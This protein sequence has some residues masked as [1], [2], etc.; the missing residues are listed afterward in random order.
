MPEPIRP[1]ALN[2]DHEAA[3]AKVDAL[4]DRALEG[5]RSD[6][7]GALVLCEEAYTLAERSDYPRGL[8]QSLNIRSRCQLRLANPEAALK[9]AAAALAQF[10]TLGDDEGREAVLSTFGIIE[11]D[12][13]HYITS[14]A[15]SQGEL[16]DTQLKRVSYRMERMEKSE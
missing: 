15:S 2:T 6:S 7:A 9:D 11:V 5:W 1:A 4:N 12:R 16:S 14:G 10:E 13:G 8:A 3:R